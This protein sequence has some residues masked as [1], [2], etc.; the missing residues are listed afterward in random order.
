MS[1]VGIVAALPAEA[2]TLTRQSQSPGSIIDSIPGLLVSACGVG[3]TAADQ[4]ARQLLQQGA[5]ALVSWGCGA[6]LTA[7]A[8]PGRLYLPSRVLAAARQQTWTV[9]PAWHE[10]LT[11]TLHNAGLAFATAPLISVTTV[12]TDSTLKQQL[13]DD[14]GAG[15]ADMESAAVAE[16]A[17]S[18]GLPFLCVRAVADN[19]SVALPPALVPVLDAYG[20]PRSFALIRRL[21]VQPTLIPRLFSLGQAFSE[22]RQTLARVAS[23]TDRQLA[24]RPR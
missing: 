6:G 20:R 22:A 17:T 15:I 19:L 13:H 11:A 7:G 1:R 4:A 5:E 23:I 3:A 2:R 8:P 16:V 14:S 10:R 21:L 18:H 12:L 24:Y 9:D